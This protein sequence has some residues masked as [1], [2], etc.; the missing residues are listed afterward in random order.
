MTIYKPSN[1]IDVYRIKAKSPD[2]RELSG[3]IGRPGLTDFIADMIVTEVRAAPTNVVI[4]IGCGDGTFL[5]RLLAVGADPWM[6]R[7][8]GVLPTAEEIIKLSTDLVS[9][10]IIGLQIIHGDAARIPVPDHF[11]DVIVCNG[12]FIYLQES[13]VSQAIAEIKRIAKPG[14]TIFIGEIPNRDELANKTYGDSISAW[15]LWVLKTHSL[16]SFLQSLRQV[17]VAMMTSELFIIYPKK[18]FH[19]EPAAFVARLAAHGLSVIKHCRHREIGEDGSE[20]Y[21]VTRWNYVSRAPQDSG[22]PAGKNLSPDG[23]GIKNAAC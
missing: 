5:K 1:F 13:E 2:L 17:I 10:G 16:K 18:L 21:H 3:R 8:I 14:A 7:L 15:L 11:A 19:A 20:R 12:V 23:S 6:G 9:Q 22:L 4:D